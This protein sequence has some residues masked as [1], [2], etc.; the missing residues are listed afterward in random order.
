MSIQRREKREGKRQTEWG[1]G[2]EGKREAE[3][4][5]EAETLL[6]NLKTCWSGTLNKLQL[7]LNK[8]PEVMPSSLLF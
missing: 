2:R 6:R 1:V 4:D 8:N 3:R 5:A 7:Q